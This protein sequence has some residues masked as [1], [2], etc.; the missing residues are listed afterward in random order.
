M[1]IGA[2]PASLLLLGALSGAAGFPFVQL[3]SHYSKPAFHV[4]LHHLCRLPWSNLTPYGWAHPVKTAPAKPTVPTVRDAIR[5]WELALSK[6]RPQ[7][8]LCRRS[9]LTDIARSHFI[10]GQEKIFLVIGALLLYFIKHRRQ[11]MQS[12]R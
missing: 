4:R 12:E 7:S 1:F 8:L 11:Y 6:L 10:S 5:D 2:E 3:G 9:G